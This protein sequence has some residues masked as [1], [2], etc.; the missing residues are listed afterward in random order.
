MQERKCPQNMF[1]P[2][3]SSVPSSTFYVGKASEHHRSLIS[4]NSSI[5]TSSNAS[6]DQGTSGALDTEESEQNQEDVTSDFVKHPSV[7]DEVFAMDQ[8]DATNEA[9]A[10]RIFEEPPGLQ[11]V[12]NDDPTVVIS[13]LGDADCRHQLHTAVAMDYADVVLDRCY[14]YSD[15]EGNP[16][17][18]ICSKCSRRFCLSELLSEGDLWLCL[19]CKSSEANSDTRISANTL[20]E[21]MNTAGDFVQIPECGSHE[22]SELSVSI[23]ES[24][25]VTCAREIRTD[26]LDSIANE[27]EL[28]YSEP[29]K[30]LS[31]PNEEGEPTLT[32]Q[33]EIGQ[34][35]DGDTCH[36]QQQQFG[37]FSNSK[38]DI[39]EGTGIP[40]LLKRSN[41]EKGHIV[42]SRSF[43][44]SNISYDDLSYVRDSVNSMRSSIGHSSASVSSSVDLGS[45][46][47]TESRIHRQSSGKRSD[48]E[49]HR[50]ETPIKHKRSI[51]SLSGASGHVLQVPSAA[52]SC[53]GDNFEV[54]AACKDNEVGGITWADPCEQSLASECT[55]AESTCTDV[56]GSIIY[57]TATEL[58]NHLINFHSGGTSVVSNLTSEDRAS[59]ENGDELTNM[60]SNSI[61]EESLAAH[62]QSSTQGEDVMQSSCVDRLDVA[63]VPQLSSL[64]VISEIEVGN[65]DTVSADSLSD[66]DSTNSKVCTN[67]LLDP[68][69]SAACDDIILTAAEEFNTS[70][71][72]NGTLGM[73]I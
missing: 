73:S 34:S 24:L 28:S 50:C 47:Q 55:E 4:R 38:V 68:S 11:H 16:D 9:V 22:N 32:T 43:T 67:E 58:S 65:A 69:V 1:R 36:Q 48:I 13:Q 49:N 19:E 72:V 63:E 35:L 70:G 45:S 64:D 21:D 61:N 71:P 57:K 25:Q 8:T 66:V 59:H 46:R 30:D 10:N 39:S 31:M 14:D 52:P 20:M 17:M 27:G 18:K 62:L 33:Q 56:E 53:L 5:T 51:S 40:L 2:L 7:H 29:S 42:Q 44:A 37:I 3:L 15:A 60:S 23:P 12:E 26:P 54:I 41:S 6:S